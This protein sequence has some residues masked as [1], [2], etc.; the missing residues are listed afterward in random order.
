MSKV[1]FQPDEFDE[2]AQNGPRGVHR[3][4]EP[5]WRW[6]LPFLVVLLVVPVVSWG[7]MYLLT[8]GRSALPSQ[9]RVV[10]VE[11]T[12]ETPEKETTPKTVE[13]ST[14]APAATL[15]P[16][17][18]SPEP[19]GAVE[20]GKVKVIVLN[21]TRVQGLAAS[22]VQKLKGEGFTNNTASNARGWAT[23]V[24]TVYYP[25]ASLRAA[26]QKVAQTL[27]IDSVK[28]FSGSKDKDAV[29]VILRSDYER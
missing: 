6:M 17:K 1:N 22:A 29:T 11:A 24:S 23:R 3:A 9:V 19:N 18:E 8:T 2:A 16:T 27:K 15:E 7:A 28:E 25:D 26:A 14:P 21:G 13:P 4:P 10:T 5:W 12:A 20:P